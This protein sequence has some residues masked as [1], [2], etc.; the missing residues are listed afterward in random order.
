MQSVSWYRTRTLA[1]EIIAAGIGSE[2]LTVA[3][4]LD[5]AAQT[6]V[7]VDRDEQVFARDRAGGLALGA[8]VDLRLQRPLDDL[9]DVGA[10]EAAHHRQQ[11][12]IV[13]GLEQRAAGVALGA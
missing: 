9:R 6:L 2:V 4:L 8:A 1:V 5:H 7:G 11:L 10:A 3:D 13:D 12:A